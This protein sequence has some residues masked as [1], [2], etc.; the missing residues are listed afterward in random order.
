MGAM[1][2]IDE[3]AQAGFLMTVASSPLIPVGWACAGSMMPMIGDPDSLLEA[4]MA[5]LDAAQEIQDAL[6]ANMDITNSLASSWQGADY[7]AF[8]QKS[9]DL[10]RQ[11]MATMSLAY[12]IGIALVLSAIAVMIACITIFVMGIGFA[13]WA[14]A[15]LFAMATVVGNLGPVEVLIFDASVWAMQCESGLATLN[16]TLGTTFNVMA[17]AVTAALAAD[18]AAQ[19]ALGNEEALGDLAQATVLSLPTIALG[20]TAKFFTERVGAGMKPPFSNNIVRGLGILLGVGQDPI[21]DATE[22]IDPSRW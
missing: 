12:V 3:M 21:G 13:I 2:G 11:L 6:T 15:I 19:V 7:D 1:S 9:A 17:G 4:G 16:S 5:W 14:A 8:V 22:D 18:V 20:L 10:S